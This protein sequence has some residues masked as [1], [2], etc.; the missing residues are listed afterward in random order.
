VSGG[1]FDSVILIDLINGRAEARRLVE[2]TDIRQRY[3]STLTRTELLTGT[4][5]DDEWQ[6]ALLLL[7]RFSQVDATAA[8]A[9][10][11]ARLRQQHRLK[12]PD[13]IIAATAAAQGVPLFTRD[14]ALAAVAG[15]KPVY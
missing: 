5:G 6:S 10:A 14:A 7:D 3:I 13:A 12:T 1:C 8:I 4:R 2:A 9:D 15:G 11:A